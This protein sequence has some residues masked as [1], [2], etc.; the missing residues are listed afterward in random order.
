MAF[1]DLT[2]WTTLPTEQR[3]AL[4]V[5]I[6]QLFFARILF[7]VLP[8]STLLRRLQRCSIGAA[9]RGTAPAGEAELIG[10]AIAAAARQ[11]PWRTDCLVQA[12][13]AKRWLEQRRIASTFHIAARGKSTGGGEDAGSLSAHAWLEVDGRPVTGGERS[14]DMITFSGT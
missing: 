13:A 8:A 10:W 5:A 14:P 1:A 2:R 6:R 9:D 3:N 4:V 12:L 7:G 11:L